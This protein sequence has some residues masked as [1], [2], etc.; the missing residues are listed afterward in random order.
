M[1]AFIPLGVIAL[2]GTLLSQDNFSESS[3]A[4]S[5]DHSKPFIE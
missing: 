3:L 2:L 5:L 1:S 4:G